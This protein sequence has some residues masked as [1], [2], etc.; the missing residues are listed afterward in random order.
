MKRGGTII[1]STGMY[2]NKP[3]DMIYTVVNRRELEILKNYIR[4]VDSSAFLTVVDA[5]EILG[6]GFKS[7]NE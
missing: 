7:L 1:N 5:N 6:N 3:V 4:S 2:N